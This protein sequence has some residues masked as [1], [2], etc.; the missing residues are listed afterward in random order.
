[1]YLYMN[2]HASICQRY[3]NFVKHLSKP[4]TFNLTKKINNQSLKCKIKSPKDLI[5]QG[6]CCRDPPAS[7]QASSRLYICQNNL[8]CFGWKDGLTDGR[9]G[10][11]QYPPQL[12][13]EGIIIWLYNKEIVIEKY[14]LHAFP[15]LK[16]RIIQ[17][18]E[19]NDCIVYC[20]IYNWPLNAAYYNGTVMI[21]V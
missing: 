10:R 20:I 21:K 14:N 18:I 9:T 2:F 19:L 13:C 6:R 4:V 15:L 8:N 3:F 11:K 5:W 12:R 16:D 17:D 7:I 1:M